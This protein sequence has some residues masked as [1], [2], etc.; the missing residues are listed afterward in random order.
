M[1]AN[2]SQNKKEFLLSI[3]TTEFF[4]NNVKGW[5][6]S[7]F[8]NRLNYYMAQEQLPLEAILWGPYYYVNENLLSIQGIILNQTY[9][10]IY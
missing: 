4:T 8:N 10:D 7:K 5:K 1:Y 6:D 9:E 2:V 3:G